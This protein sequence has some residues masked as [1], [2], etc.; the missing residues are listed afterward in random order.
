M[1]IKDVPEFQAHY[2]LTIIVIVIGI[3][4]VGRELRDYFKNKTKSDLFLFFT[5]LCLGLYTLYDL[6]L[7]SGHVFSLENTMLI[8]EFYMNFFPVVISNVIFG[9]L[10]MLIFMVWILRKS[11]MHTVKKWRAAVIWIL[12]VAILLTTT[13]GSGDFILDGYKV[14]IVNIPQATLSLTILIAV[15]ILLSERASIFTFLRML[16]KVSP[17]ETR[18]EY[19]FLILG[20]YNYFSYFLGVVIRIHFGTSWFVIILSD[21]I[22][23]AAVIVAFINA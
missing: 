21:V 8:Q 7:T 9:M 3:M 1:G 18:N 2:I 5:Y 12:A 13:L 15:M 19:K 6:V 14:K 16:A 11:N 10:L 20:N 22:F 4:V 23:L 17:F